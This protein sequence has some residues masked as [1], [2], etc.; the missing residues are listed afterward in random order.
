MASCSTNVPSR[1]VLE[2][3]ELGMQHEQQHQELLL[4][5]IKHVLSRNPM[6]P[7]FDAIR[8][9]RARCVPNSHLDDLWGWKLRHRVLRG[10][11]LLRQRAPRHR[12]YLRPFALS[13]ELVTC[14]EWLDFMD[15]DGYQRPELWLS[16]GWATVQSEGWRAPSYWA[17]S[18]SGWREFTLG[19]SI[20]AQ[21]PRS[22]YATSA[23]T[24][25][26]RS[27][28]GPDSACPRKPSGRSPPP[29]PRRKVTSRQTRLHPS[30]AIDSPGEIS[31]FREP[32]AVDVVCLQSVP[33]FSPPKERSVSTTA[34]SWSTSTCCVAARA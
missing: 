12:V 34:N 31:H 20:P 30:P 10:G 15:D 28:A 17:E 18:E 14:D 27:P 2:L 29:V 25:P 26:T 1:P 8:A 22:P 9:P 13:D 3:A 19:G 24:K 11:L 7:A 23:T 32:L 5:D 6:Q 16:D 21:T 33:S 4:M